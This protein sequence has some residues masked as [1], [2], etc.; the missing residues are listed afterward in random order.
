M[1]IHALMKIEG[2]IRDLEK[3]LKSVN[4]TLKRITKKKPVVMKLTGLV[5]LFLSSVN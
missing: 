2:D 1:C 3:K 4:S 5:N